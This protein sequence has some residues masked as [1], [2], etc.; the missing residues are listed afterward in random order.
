MARDPCGPTDMV[1]TTP[2]AIHRNGGA[3]T[4]SNPWPSRVVDELASHRRPSRGCRPALPARP[5]SLRDRRTVRG[6]RD[7][8]SAE[9]GSRADYGYGVDC[10][11][12]ASDTSP[13]SDHGSHA[14]RVD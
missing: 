10:V 14:P 11:R 7:G 12:R 2:I 4:C 3:W 5:T 9:P 8:P 6:D 1:H 13:S